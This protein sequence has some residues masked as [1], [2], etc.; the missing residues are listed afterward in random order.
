MS[1]LY[2]AEVER[3]ARSDLGLCDRPF[4][5]HDH[6]YSN[7]VIHSHLYFIWSL[8]NR[9]VAGPSRN[10]DLSVMQKQPCQLRGWWIL[11]TQSTAAAA[12]QASCSTA[13]VLIYHFP[14]FSRRD[15]CDCD[16]AFI[17]SIL[18]QE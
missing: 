2:Q 14:S 11:S 10:V 4:R 18:E 9:L 6:W 8:L 3:G 15:D 5:R 13:S 16:E 1:N 7:T 12:S 17:I